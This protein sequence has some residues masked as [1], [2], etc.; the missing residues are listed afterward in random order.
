MSGLSIR[1]IQATLDTILPNKDVAIEVSPSPVQISPKQA[2][3][4]ALII[5]KLVLNMWS[6][7]TPWQIE[8]PDVLRCS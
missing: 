1:V 7:N 4:M 3:V 6:P 2:H 5:H 8:Q